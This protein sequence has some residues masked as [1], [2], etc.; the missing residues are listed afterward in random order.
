M[1]VGKYVIL[2]YVQDTD[3][4]LCSMKESD[5]KTALKSFIMVAP[6]DGKKEADWY[7]VDN[8]DDIK[9]IIKYAKDDDVRGV[10]YDLT[11]VP[12]K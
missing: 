12:N 5:Q 8:E 9:K 11:Y 7:R 1:N 3:Y 2:F 10:I 4:R 6:I